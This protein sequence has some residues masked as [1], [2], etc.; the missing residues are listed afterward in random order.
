[1]VLKLESVI[2]DR[3]LPLCVCEHV[4]Y[5]CVSVCVCMH[6]CV[7]VCVC[8]SIPKICLIF[9]NIFVRFVAFTFM[10]FFCEPH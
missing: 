10:L 1:M 7:Y 6:A 8:V 5:V 4:S 9:L 3:I 2:K